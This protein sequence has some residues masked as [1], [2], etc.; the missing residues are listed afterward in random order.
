M[1]SFRKHQGL[2]H[3]VEFFAVG[4]DDA[5]PSARRPTFNVSAELFKTR[6]EAE[7]A[8]DGK[9]VGVYSFFAK[10]ESDVDSILKQHALRV[11]K[12]V[13]ALFK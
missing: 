4:F 3:N 1:I 9:I 13:N 7:K 2:G 11:E 6:D 5:M 10:S 12:Y 8:A